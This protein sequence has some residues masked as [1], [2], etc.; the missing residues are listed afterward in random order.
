MR[1]LVKL[2]TVAAALAFAAGC[3]SGSS[4][5]RRPEAPAN[6]TYPIA[7][8]NYQRVYNTTYHVVNRY[9][10]VKKASYRYG[11]IEAE[12]SQDNALFDKTRRTILARIFDAGDYWDVECRVLI[13]VEDSEVESLDEHQPRYNWRTIASDSLM[14]S[15]LNN[16]VKAALSGG[17]W[18]AKAPLVPD[19]RA[20]V[21]P[22][23]PPRIKI[24]PAEPEGPGA[25]PPLP[26]GEEEGSKEEKKPSNLR[27]AHAT[28]PSTAA[29]PALG[30]GHGSDTASA[31]EQSEQEYERLGLKLMER[32]EYAKAVKAFNAAREA[33]PASPFASYLLAH[34]LLRDGRVRDRRGRH[35]R[36]FGAQPRVAARR[37]RSQELLRRRRR[38]PRPALQARDLLRRA[39]RRPGRP[40]GPRLR[41]VLQPRLPARRAGLCRHGEGGSRCRRRAQ[42]GPRDDL[43]APRAVRARP[44]ARARGVLNF[45]ASL[46]ARSVSFLARGKDEPPSRPR[47][48]Q[49]DAAPRA[50]VTERRV[51]GNVPPDAAP[52]TKRRSRRNPK[53][54]ASSLE[55]DVTPAPGV[56]PPPPKP[57]TPEAA[58]EV[59]GRITLRFGLDRVRYVGRLTALSNAIL[60]AARDIKVL[61]SLEW[62][63]EVKERFFES[64]ERELPRPVYPE[65]Q[66][67]L[68]RAR[69]TLEEIRRSITGQNAVDS[70]LRQTCD[71]YETAA[72][73]L[74]CLGTTEFYG[75]SRELYG[76]AGTRF[77][78]GTTTNL[79][80]AK[81]LARTLS[82]YRPAALGAPDE[83]KLTALE[84]APL[85]HARFAKELPGETIEVLIAD[86][87]AS[88]AIAG[89]E[90]VRI[91]RDA[92][93]SSR[94]VEILVHH[95]GLVHV[96]TT[97]NGRRQP[98]LR[99]LGKGAPRTMRVQ[100]GLAVFAE[101]ITGSIDVDRLRRL[102]DRIIAIDMSAQGAGFLELYRFFLE[103]GDGRD[104]AFDNAQ[105]VVRGGKIGGGAPFTKDVVYLDG[106][107][108]IH[109]YLTVAVP[110]GRLDDVG[111]LFV[112]KISLE[113]IPALRELEN[114]S[115]ITPP[116][117][118]PYWARDLRFLA[119]YLSYS[120]FLKRI[121]LSALHA[122]YDR[123]FGTDDSEVAAIPD[124]E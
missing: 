9:A 36:G 8:G 29:A 65:R 63:P 76:D 67:D 86:D 72:R 13:Q 22:A 110:R 93:F 94:E 99:L 114:E 10:V 62:E 30:R 24:I 106:L 31:S 71:S 97:L 119:A 73:M 11:E 75:L 25:A 17:A 61:P 60:E 122:L 41:G 44:R 79:D 49:P 96:A 47:E 95:E 90:H 111:R 107:T 57:P 64:H 14:E 105:R 117:H 3:A 68:E 124:D 84:V 38:S 92:L 55:G 123:H 1:N 21:A 50:P 108:R 4:S 54:E 20:R 46:R 74:C 103:R 78:D 80:L 83:Q 39:S 113:D 32:G 120:T 88:K 100:E 70:W 12:V 121:D 26:Q 7:F 23:G 101:F 42:R 27:D 112:G 40:A 77:V 51:A 81:H 102:A 85:L 45:R 33:R 91:R 69:A 2:G 98:H 82:I 43:P 28:T 5:V 56:A 109:G 58:P 18:E 116:L 15:K 16:E 53:L 104:E 59:P 52:L 6:V 115:I 87:I 19:S 34:G 37:P 66:G 48:G 89:P 118:M 35:S